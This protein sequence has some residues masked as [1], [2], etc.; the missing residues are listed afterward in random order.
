MNHN[1]KLIYF[2]SSIIAQNNY[3]LKSCYYDSANRY[4]DLYL[5][6]VED[7]ILIQAFKIGDPIPVK[8]WDNN[9]LKRIA[10]N[11]LENVIRNKKL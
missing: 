3:K 2:L 4:I 7:A 10:R 6:T 1:I 11:R 9:G 5:I 8:K